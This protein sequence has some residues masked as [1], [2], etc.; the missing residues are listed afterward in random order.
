VNDVSSRRVALI[1]VDER[2]KK[3]VLATDD[4]LSQHERW[5]SVTTCRCPRR[6]KSRSILVDYTDG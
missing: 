5:L 4:V 6:R 2:P 3:W 1:D